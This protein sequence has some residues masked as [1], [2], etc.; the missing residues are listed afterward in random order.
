MLALLKMGFQWTDVQD[1][2]E[3]EV[4]G[5]L[6]ASLPKPKGKKFIVRKK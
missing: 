1:M 4:L 2:P 6:K 3:E 5:W